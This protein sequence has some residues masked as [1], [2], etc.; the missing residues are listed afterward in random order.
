MIKNLPK[1][2]SLRKVFACILLSFAIGRKLC[3]EAG[4][5][6]ELQPPLLT[7]SLA[8]HLHHA[9][10]VAHVVKEELS[11]LQPDERAGGISLVAL[12]DQVL[13]AQGC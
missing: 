1:T 8:I 5:G 6:L 13:E 10:E 9:I 2:P 7:R 3:H 4:N 12:L 11:I